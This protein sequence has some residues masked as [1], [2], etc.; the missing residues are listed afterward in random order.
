MQW[1]GDV[2]RTIGSF[3]SSNLIGFLQ[4]FPWMLFS[5]VVFWTWLRNFLSYYTHYLL[6]STWSLLESS[7]ACCCCWT[8]KCILRERKSVI[9]WDMVLCC[10]ISATLPVLIKSIFLT[11]SQTSFVQ[12]QYWGVGRKEK[13]WFG[14]TSCGNTES[15]LSSSHCLQPDLGRAVSQTQESKKLAAMKT[16]LI[17]AD[18]KS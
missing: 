15:C 4:C 7:P 5:F 1:L 13:L 8:C 10:N 17:L 2:G 3:S 9:F 11:W 18:F 16:G 12:D 14:K 6:L